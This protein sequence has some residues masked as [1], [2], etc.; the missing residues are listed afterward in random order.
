MHMVECNS[1]AKSVPSSKHT[2]THTQ[3]ERERE[4]ERETRTHAH[5]H[6]HTHTHTHK[7]YICQCIHGH[8][9]MCIL[10][11]TCKVSPLIQYVDIDIDILQI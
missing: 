8:R 11:T 9:Y 3:R 4:R 7:L 10:Y 1:S 5:T 6:T 2:H